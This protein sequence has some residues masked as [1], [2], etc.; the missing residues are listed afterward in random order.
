MS[1]SPPERFCT[2]LT[3]YET[4]T[5]ICAAAVPIALAIFTVISSGQDAKGADQKRQ[6]DLE[7]AEKLRQEHIYDQF[8]SDFY[9]MN[10]DGQLNESARPWAFANARYR[11]ANQ[12]WESVWKGYSLQFLKEKQLIGRRC[13][14]REDIIRL[15][16]MNFQQIQ[17]ASLDGNLYQLD[18]MCVAFDQVSMIGATI[19][20]TNLDG[21]SFD[22][23]SLNGVIFENSSLIGASFNGT[24][25]DSTDFSGSNLQGASFV[26]VDLSKTKLTSEQMQQATFI[27]TI[28][29][30]GTI[31]GKPFTEFFV[32]LSPH[33]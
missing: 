17:L 15:N 19:A 16:K 13:D 5:L 22:S 25:L 7:L 30:N 11:A 6:F 20:N 28:M 24:Q 12:Q 23:S 3:L 14:G 33:K 4:L 8:L 1:S 27:N 31:S 10:K 9:T 21:S 32:K 18:M 29:P 26:N 2:R